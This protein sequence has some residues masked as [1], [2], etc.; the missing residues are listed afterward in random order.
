M[1]YKEFNV[2]VDGG[3]SIRLCHFPLSMHNNCDMLTSTAMTAHHLGWT[4]EVKFS[5]PVLDLHS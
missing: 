1:M 2:S 3:M 5:K 4:L